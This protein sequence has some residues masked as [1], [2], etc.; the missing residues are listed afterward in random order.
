MGGGEAETENLILL[1][2]KRRGRDRKPDFVA[3][4]ARIVSGWVVMA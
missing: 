4:S 2:G 1:E 3:F